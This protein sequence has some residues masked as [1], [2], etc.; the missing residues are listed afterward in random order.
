MRLTQ[1]F[2]VLV[3]IAQ[4][5]VSYGQQ[6]LPSPYEEVHALVV[7]VEDYSSSRLNTLSYAIDDAEELGRVLRERYG[8]RVR[9]LRDATKGEILSALEEYRGALGSKDGFIF[10]FAGHGNSVAGSDPLGPQR[11]GYFVPKIG[12]DLTALSID[13]VR[14]SFTEKTPF[15]PPLRREATEDE[16]GQTDE[17]FA[18][19]VRLAKELWERERVTQE[20]DA[21]V[22]EGSIRMDGLSESLMRLPCKHVVGIF[23]ACFSGLATRGGGGASAE[24]DAQIAFFRHYRLLTN[25]SRLLFTAG[26]GG[27]ETIEHGE[28]S[29]GYEHIRSN[30]APSA[31]KHGVFTYELLGVLSNAPEVGQSLSAMHQEVTKRVDAVMSYMEGERH[32]TPQL[33]PYGGSSGDG[34]FVFVPKPREMWLAKAEKAILTVLADQQGGGQ[35]RGAIEIEELL[36]HDAEDERFQRQLDRLQSKA[37]NV[38]CF[39]AELDT[40]VGE[41]SDDPVWEDRFA[42][43]RS[44]AS[45]GDPDAM[46]ALF[47]MYRHGLGV[48]PSPQQA[49]HWA[50]EAA[51]SGSPDAQAAWAVALREGTGIDGTAA[52]EG[53]RAAALAAA[54]KQATQQKTAAIAAAGGVAALN[55]NNEAVAG[56]L[57]ATAA[58]SFVSSLRERP[59]ESIELSIAKIE[60]D[61]DDLG[62]LIGELELK[63]QADMSVFDGAQASIRARQRG[64]VDQ[65]RRARQGAVERD[66]LLDLINLSTRELVQSMIDLRKPLVRKRAGPARAEFAEVEMA[67]AK[68]VALMPYQLYRVSWD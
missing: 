10:F 65:I 18:E 14:E 66:L 33:R 31:I 16:P 6:R 44:Q 3:V 1:S 22:I 4:A 50:A 25:R 39:R 42:F 26:T 28:K 19:A 12:Q 62:D 9:V 29:R 32:M 54:E 41:L 46:A 61:I 47:Y 30:L 38:L 8:Y 23:D 2:V 60:R 63:G 67:Y 34:E 45:T 27:Q 59:E 55:G 48:A 51:A 68:L 5:C 56:V 7:G 53:D 40:S 49:G 52:L 35:G 36:E 43:A 64:I 37:L 58:A 15:E 17:E 24:F 20:H 57:L 21:R 11:V 13:D